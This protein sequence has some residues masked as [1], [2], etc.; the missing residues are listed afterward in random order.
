MGIFGQNQFS[1]QTGK[2]S[3]EITVFLLKTVASLV[4]DHDV[5]DAKEKQQQ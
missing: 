5:H 1:W 2:I 3:F 4:Y